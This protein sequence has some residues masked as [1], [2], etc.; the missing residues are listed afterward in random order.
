MS[1]NY[2][3]WIIPTIEDKLELAG[4][5]LAGDILSLKSKLSKFNRIHIGKQ[6]AGW[7]FLFNH[8]KAEFYHDKE[9]FLLWLDTIQITSEYGETVNK[10][11]FLKVFERKDGAYALKSYKENPSW[12]V[13]KDDMV[14]SSSTEFC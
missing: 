3:G 2:Y 1:N 11:E 13:F 5:A 9:S 7:S 14:F 6:S 4:L 8:N 10:E 12:Y